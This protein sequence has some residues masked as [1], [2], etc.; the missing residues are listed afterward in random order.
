LLKWDA[1]ARDILPVVEKEMGIPCYPNWVSAW[2]YDDKVKQYYLMRANGFPMTKSWIFYDKKKA[3]D[4]DQTAEYPLVFKSRAGAG[5]MNVILVESPTEDQKLIK[6][7]F[8]SGLVDFNQDQ[9]DLRCVEIALE[10]SREMGFPSTAYDFMYNEKGEPKFCEISYNYG[11]PGYRDKDL[12]WHEGHYWPEYLHLM[13]GLDLPDLK[14]P[15]T[16]FREMF[17]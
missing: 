4:W 3:Q 14:I 8:G 17:K 6:R 2:H 10:V 7:V 12:T 16:D 1:F 9:I 11:C 13:D 5:S 15:E